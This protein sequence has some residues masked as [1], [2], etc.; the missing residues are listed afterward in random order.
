MLDQFNSY[1]N[2]NGYINLDQIKNKFIINNNIYGSRDK[3]WL[4]LNGTKVLF[5]ENKRHGE[6]IKEMVNQEI[7]RYLKVS[8]ANYDLAIKEGKAGVITLPFF[9]GKQVFLPAMLLLFQSKTVGNSNDILSIY[10]ALVENNASNNELIC[11]MNAYF[12]NQVQDIFTF[13]YDRNME[14]SGIILDDKKFLPGVRFDS[15]GS[16]LKF[17]EDRKINSF[18]LR[19]DRKVCVYN[20]NYGRTKLRITPTQTYDS[21]KEFIQFRYLDEFNSKLPEIMKDS[22]KNMDSSVEKMYNYNLKETFDKLSYYNINVSNMYQK[23]IKFC[24]DLSKER[25]E[26]DMN[27]IQKYGTI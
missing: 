16:F 5:I 22:I 27:K 24:L 8:S 11:I 25:F 13:Q 6:D 20:K 12:L 1:R 21:I 2:K 23:L 10:N 7:S 4:S 9:T 19:Q 15:A 3:E 17:Y 14:N 26:D 18:L